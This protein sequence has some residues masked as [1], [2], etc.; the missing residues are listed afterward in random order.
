MRLGYPL[1]VGHDSRTLYEFRFDTY[2][3]CVITVEAT[4]EGTTH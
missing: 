2:T 4:N 3:P 1:K